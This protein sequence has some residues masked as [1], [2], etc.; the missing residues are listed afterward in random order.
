M[1]KKIVDLFSFWEF[2]EKKCRKKIVD[3][4]LGEILDLEKVTDING[5]GGDWFSFSCHPPFFYATPGAGRR[6]FRVA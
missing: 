4:F 2:M 6:I 3:I 1:R 5:R